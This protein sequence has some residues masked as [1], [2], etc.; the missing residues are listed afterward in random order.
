MSTRRK[1]TWLKPYAYLYLAALYAPVLLLPLFAFNDSAVV[2][3]P[4]TGFTT[5][6]FEQL[7]AQTVLHQAVWNSLFV[8]VSSAV[9]ATCLG[10]CAARASAR[11]DFPGKKSMMGFIMVPL[12]L[13]EIIIA[14]ALLVVLVQMGMSLSL[15][16]VILGHVLI[17]TPFSIAILTSSFLNLD[18]SLEEASMDL[19]E[20]RLGTF[21]RVTLPLVTP[22]VISSLLISFTISLDEF[23]IAFFLTGTEPTLPVYIWS[24]LRFTAKLPGVVALGFVLL[25]LSLVLLFTAEYF[26]RRANARSGATETAGG[27]FM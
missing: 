2:S 6:W 10:I 11:Y 27:G 18:Q 19:G 16:S 8:G 21:L 12:V 24:Q 7:W 1:G 14:V 26:R 25:V 3:F 22:G 4:L 15:W 17:C 9:I 23:I 20:T 5:K 13:P